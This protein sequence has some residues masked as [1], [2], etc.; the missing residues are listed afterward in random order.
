M[1][2]TPAAALAVVAALL[3]VLAGAAEPVNLYRVPDKG[4]AHHQR[5]L[6]LG[7]DIVGHE[8]GELHVA[9]TE[10]QLT[11]IGS[12]GAPAALL[13]AATPVEAASAMDPTLGLYHSYDEM[14]AALQSL[15][16][17][18]PSLCSLQSIGQS[19]EG[20]DIWVLRIEGNGAPARTASKPH[21]FYGGCLHARELMSV[22]I[23]LRFAQHLLDNYASDPALAQLVDSRVSWVAP[24]L[25]PDGHVYVEQN[26]SGDWWTWWRKNR[27][28]NGDGSFGVD[29]NRNFSFEW[30]YDNTGSSPT[31]SSL[32]YRGPAPFS[33]PETVALRDFLVANP[34]ALS[35]SYHSY[36]ELLLYPWGY[37]RG[38]TVD[39]ELFFE[40]GEELTA[41]N[42]Y[43][44]GNAAMG[45]IYTVNGDS[46]DWA[47]GELSGGKPSFPMFT[48]ELNSQA[49]GGFGP[50]DT[51][52]QPTVDLLLPMNLALLELADEPRRVLGPLPPLLSASHGFDTGASPAQLTLS[53][54]APDPGD[55]N[56]AT[57]YALQQFRDLGHAPVDDASTLDPTRWQAGGFGHDA[58]GGL[59]GGGAF[60]SGSG[61]D[62]ANT[63]AMALP[64]RVSP[65]Q[66]SF[67][68]QARYDIEADWDYA[69]LQL[70]D[71]GGLVWQ[72]VAGNITT[73]S[74]PNGNN[75]GHGITGSTGGGWVA[76]SFDLSAWAG[77]EV[78]LRFAYITDGYVTGA[79]F[80]A[81]DLGPVADAADVALVL[82]GHPS[83][84]AQL[85]ISETGVYSYRVRGRD[86]DDDTGRWGPLQDYLL[87]P[88]TG[89]GERLPSASVLR[90]NVPNPFNPATVI[91][92][93]VG[94]TGEAQVALEI[95]DSAGRRVRALVG[96]P[97]PAGQHQRHFDG[98]DDGGRALPSG[99]YH[100]RLSVDGKL[101]G[102]RKLLLAK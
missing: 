72:S 11:A 56:P 73:T 49:Q 37:V 51:L 16:S 52:I 22:E 12:A 55:P 19:V 43:Y 32:V 90:R 60:F 6:E 25:N 99:V 26:N 14:V 93:T 24:M 4:F 101:G 17:T 10:R 98:R 20:R 95:F 7:V 18:Y 21:V 68:F 30:G 41:T 64:Y 1:R 97:L 53:W 78:Q 48:P 80:W 15:A 96:G 102:T 23:P 58:T 76:A 46:D 100:A 81:D 88:V 66:E 86:A 77:Q 5:L 91:P 94:G 39:H 62:L 31:T 35:F 50:P 38:Y 67:E 71:D 42:G 85:P 40:L 44:A 82:D 28:D 87:D 36:G 2:L 9:A 79:G 29:L 33:E 84:S 75:A 83:T 69:Y 54:S 57:G 59:A 34:P 27:R 8:R 70:S 89:T 92:F 63:L 13:Q 47:Y 65:G 3:P 61:D 45:A 74:D